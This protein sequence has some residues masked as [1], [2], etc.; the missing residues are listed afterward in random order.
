M[1]KRAAFLKA[2][3][4]M[5]DALSRNIP[6][7]LQT[8]VC[9]CLVH[10]R[11]HFVEIIENFP[12]E[13][14]YVIE[15][16]AIVYRHEAFTR[17][18]AMSPEERLAYHQ[19]HSALVMEELKNWCLAKQENREVEPNSELGKAVKYLLKHWKELTRF[20]HVPGAPL[21]NNVYE[22]AL[23]HAA[24]HRENASFFKTPRGAHVGDLFMSLIHTG[25]VA[26][27]SPMD[28]LCAVLKNAARVEKDPMAWMPWNYRHNLTKGPP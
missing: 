17:Q 1:L 27:E 10:A 11:R 12:E 28:E 16:L 8:I 13:C 25:E 24:L 20:C 4:Q 18:R 21:D 26:G 5:C 2:P 22:R 15:Q 3:L 9:Y 23:K 19:S 7:A 6:S 14:A